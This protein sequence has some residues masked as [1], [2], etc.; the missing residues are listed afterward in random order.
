MDARVTR[1]ALVVGV[2]AVPVYLLV[3]D[4]MKALKVQN[5]LLNVFLTGVVAYEA[6]EYSGFLSWYKLREQRSNE[7]PRRFAYHSNTDNRIC[8]LA[9]DFAYA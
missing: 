8:S 9:A 2:G 4:V 1:N 7:R 3:R 6:A 5:E